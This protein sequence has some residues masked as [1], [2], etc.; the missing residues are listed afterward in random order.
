[1][2]T[3]ESLL[4]RAAELYYQQGLSQQRIAELFGVSR[5]TVSRLL[6]EARACG[7]VEIRVHAP[8]R[9]DA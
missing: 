8:L 3:K 2:S 1:M 5:P 9:K 6:D 7:I 4:I